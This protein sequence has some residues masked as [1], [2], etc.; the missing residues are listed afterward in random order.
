[1]RSL[2]TTSALALAALLS[3]G[4]PGERAIVTP[5]GLRPATRRE[6]QRD[7][8]RGP[9]PE[10][11]PEESQERLSSAEAK[12]ERRRQRNLRLEVVK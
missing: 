1:M 2:L 12:R 8:P 3:T 4:V 9:R 5:T 11:S 7:K 10:R 6:L